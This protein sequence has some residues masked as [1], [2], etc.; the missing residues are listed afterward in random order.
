[1]ILNNV[2]KFPIVIIAPPR[3]GSIITC[4][5]IGVDLGIRHFFDLTYRD[6]QT[7]FNE[8]LDFAQTNDQYVIKFHSYDIEKYPTWL[9]DKIYNGSTYNVKV[10]RNNTSLQIAS[11]YIAGIRDQFHYNSENTEDY[12]GPIDINTLHIV[13]AIRHIR[14][15]IKE[16]ENLSVPFDA[17]IEYENCKYTDDISIKTPLPSNYNELLIRINKLLKYDDKVL[18]AINHVLFKITKV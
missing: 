1:M 14:R 15:N 4:K 7:E 10:I 3:S 2:T 17:V 16:L 6:N 18:A 13:E 5:Q 12:I 11:L 9:T 8:F